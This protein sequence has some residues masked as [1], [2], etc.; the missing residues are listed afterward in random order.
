MLRHEARTQKS[1]MLTILKDVLCTRFQ[2]R[3]EQLEHLGNV[4]YSAWVS[5]PVSF[6]V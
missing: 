5:Q 4:E 1:K 6:G 3:E 2:G